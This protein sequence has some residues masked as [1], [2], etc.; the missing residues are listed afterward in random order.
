MGVGH[1]ENFPVASLLLPRRLRAPVHAIYRFAREAD[2]LADEGDVAPESRRAALD[3]R[4]AELDRI[5]RSSPPASAIYRDLARHIRAHALPLAPFR[6][7]LSAFRQDTCKCRYATFAEVEDYCRRSANPVGHLLLHLYGA[8]TPDALALSDAICTALQLVNFLQDIAIDHERGR[9]YMPEDELTRFGLREA[10]IAA[11][12]PHASWRRFMRFQTDRTRRL[13]WR[14]APLARM[15]GGRLGMELKLIVLGGDRIIEKI[16]A[17]DGDIFHHRPVLR[18]PDWT[19][20]A[21]RLLLNREPDL[22]DA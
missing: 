12:Q 1:Y 10:D 9:V 13:L 19:V 14:G 11:G 2:D 15:L 3:A 6:A 21:A 7:L 20:M 22:R 4:E 16:R 8:A 5:E 18:A 17:V